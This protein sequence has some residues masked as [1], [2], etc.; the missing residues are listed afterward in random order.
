MSRSRQSTPGMPGIAR[1]HEVGILRLAAPSWHR[2]LPAQRLRKNFLYLARALDRIHSM[3]TQPA[4][5]RMPAGDSDRC[6]IAHGATT[7]ATAH[8]IDSLCM[9]V[10]LMTTLTWSG[11]RS[12]PC[13]PT[14]ST[15]THNRLDPSWPIRSQSGACRDAF[16]RPSPQVFYVGAVRGAWPRES[17]S[18]VIHSS[19]FTPPLCRSS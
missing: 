14:N 11:L 5:A 18:Q 17:L 6:I 16:K 10:R 9:A 7:A 1:Q 3:S 2:C 13:V 15:R 8:D 19:S 12:S 4:V